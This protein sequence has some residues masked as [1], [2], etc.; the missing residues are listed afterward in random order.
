MRRQIIWLSVCAACLGLIF[1]K[2]DGGIIFIAPLIL[3]TF[4]AG[5]GGFA[6]FSLLDDVFGHALGWD[7]ANTIAAKTSYIGSLWF[8]IVAA[9]HQQG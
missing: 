9:R 2:P 8:L 1:V 4:P 7:L 5:L 3:L 6:L